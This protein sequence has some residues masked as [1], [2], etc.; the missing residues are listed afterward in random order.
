MAPSVHSA[1]GAIRNITVGEDA[2]GLGRKQAAVRAGAALAILDALMAPEVRD[3]E[4]DAE[5][6]LSAMLNIHSQE[7]SR[8]IH[9]QLQ[10]R[11]GIGGFLRDGV[12]PALR[13]HRRSEQMMLYGMSALNT[14]TLFFKGQALSEQLIA[15][16]IADGGVAALVLLLRTQPR[17]ETI[18][19]GAAGTLL[20]WFR[21]VARPVPE[22]QTTTTTSTR[23]ATNNDEGRCPIRAAFL[24]AGV[25]KAAL[26]ALKMSEG[27]VNHV[28]E[29]IAALLQTNPG[30]MDAASEELSENVKSVFPTPD[31]FRKVFAVAASRAGGHYM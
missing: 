22:E 4:E 29:L 14:Y 5:M 16:A 9:Q 15:Q 7:G 3:D 31:S 17:D 27:R 30:G 6:C 24:A 23:G 12:L 19:G 26:Y 2:K 28:Y 25:D 20:G 1:A 18:G 13:A 11:G 21:A 10:P 8:T